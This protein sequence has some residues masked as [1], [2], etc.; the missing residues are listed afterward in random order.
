MVLHQEWFCGSVRAAAPAPA[1]P[2]VIDWPYSGGAG[3]GARALRRWH[4]RGRECRSG[5]QAAALAVEAHLQQLFA[6][7]DA[8]PERPMRCMAIAYV[9]RQRTD[10][11]MGDARLCPLCCA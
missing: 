8:S 6:H 10:E 7:V 2:H 4:A 1:P 9:S 11:N 5:R 3:V